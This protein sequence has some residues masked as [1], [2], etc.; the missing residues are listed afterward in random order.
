MDLT[1]AM[2]TAV[3]GWVVAKEKKG[4][5]EKIKKKGLA[6]I[7]ELQKAG[8]HTIVFLRCRNRLGFGSLVWDL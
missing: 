5:E 8:S 6:D 3:Y 2:E 4:K 7:P 1:L